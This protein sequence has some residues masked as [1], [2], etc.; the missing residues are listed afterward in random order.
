MIMDAMAGGWGAKSFADGVNTAGLMAAITGQ[1]P[2][3]ETNEGLYPIL[4][5]YRRETKDSG[6]PGEFRGG[7]GATSCWIPYDT[8]DRSIELVLATFG[9]A[10]PTALGIDGGYPS[11]TSMYKMVRNSDVSGWLKRGEIPTDLAV[12]EGEFE[13]LPQKCETRQFADDVFE[14]TW[15]G[16]GGYGDP[17]RRAPERVLDDVVNDA[18]SLDAAREIYGV[19]IANGKVNSDAT[20]RERDRIRARRLGRAPKTGGGRNVSNSNGRLSQRLLVDGKHN[21]VCQSCGH[22]V[23]PLKKN[24]KLNLVRKDNNIQA[25]NPLIVDPKLFIDPE[26]V[27]RQYFCPSCAVQIET[28]V[29]LASSEPVWDKELYFDQ[30]RSTGPV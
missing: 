12:L 1:C 11:N 30:P 7:M 22:V 17:I 21:V 5:L 24:Y 27:F 14:Q 26:V 16:G 8:D 3:I 2:N 29:L 15:G 19:V 23:G 4:Y 6:G 20:T 9:Q 10:F 13:Y 25:A 28:E 18:V